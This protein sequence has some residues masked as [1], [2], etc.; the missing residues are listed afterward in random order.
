MISICWTHFEHRAYLEE[1]TTAKIDGY[2]FCD[3]YMK[4]SL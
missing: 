1:L 3:T 2:Q 4:K